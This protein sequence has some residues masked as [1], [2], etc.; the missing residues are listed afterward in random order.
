M[1]EIRLFN[2]LQVLEIHAPQPGLMTHTAICDAVAGKP[3]LE[4]LLIYYIN[5]KHFVE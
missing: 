5:D 3:N 2:Q 4:H 1:D